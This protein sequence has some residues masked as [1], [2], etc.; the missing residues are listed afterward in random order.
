MSP[1]AVLEVWTQLFTEC[2]QQSWLYFKKILHEGCGNMRI[3][4]AYTEIAPLIYNVLE[5]LEEE[6]E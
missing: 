6:V 5:T 4:D 2:L 3:S 1:H